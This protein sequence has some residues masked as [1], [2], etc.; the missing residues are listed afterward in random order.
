MSRPAVSVSRSAS[1][2]TARFAHRR[3]WAIRPHGCGA[4]P[5]SHCRQCRPGW[6]LGGF[7]RAGGP[8][9]RRP[10]RAC[11]A[12]A[13]DDAARRAMPSARRPPVPPVAAILAVCRHRGSADRRRQCSFLGAT[14]FTAA[15]AIDQAGPATPAFPVHPRPD[16]AAVPRGAAGSS[17]AG[18]AAVR[19]ASRAQLDAASI[20]LVGRSRTPICSFARW[21]RIA[22][23]P[24]G[25]RVCSASSDRPDRPAHPGPPHPRFAGRRSS[26]A[27]RSCRPKTACPACWC[28]SHPILPGAGLARVV[29][30]ADRFGLRVRQAPRPTALDRPDSPVRWNL[31]RGDRGPAQS[32]PGAAGPRW[33]GAADPRPPRHRDRRGRHDRQRA[34]APGGGVRP[35]HC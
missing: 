6:R 22:G 2:A 23:R 3:A 7:I 27:R 35:R 34:C 14:L 33:H 20:L 28:S 24:F 13:V 18:A 30:E 9:A 15:T 17:T 32:P 19:T 11:L 31:A 25:W 4:F 29:A 21:P 1:T 16:V 8:L 12:S 5:D 10:G 26:R